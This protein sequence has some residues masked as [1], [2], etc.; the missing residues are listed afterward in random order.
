MALQLRQHAG[1]LSAV[2]PGP[3]AEGSP[4]VKTALSGQG[5]VQVRSHRAAARSWVLTESANPTPCFF[6]LRRDFRKGECGETP[7]R[8]TVSNTTDTLHP[9]VTPR[10]A[11]RERRAGVGV[12]PQALC[13]QER[14]VL[15]DGVKCIFMDLREEGGGGRDSSIHDER[16][17]S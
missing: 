14:G 6:H 17:S 13:E 7:Q 4:K 10:L 15:G 3:A 2:G 16:E 9:A 5:C 8:P 11:P 12:L 1:A